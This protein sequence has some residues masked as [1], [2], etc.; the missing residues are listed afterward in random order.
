MV[1]DICVAGVQGVHYRGSDIVAM[2]CSVVG[3]KLLTLGTHA[4]Q[5]VRPL[6]ERRAYFLIFE[7]CLLTTRQ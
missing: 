1:H 2:A 3:V 5:N 4:P 7:T 6:W